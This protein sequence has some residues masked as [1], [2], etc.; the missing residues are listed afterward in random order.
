M[1]GLAI[2]L[3]VFLWLLTFPT[4]SD[5]GWLN[6]LIGSIAIGIG[7]FI[8]KTVARY[9]KLHDLKTSI[10]KTKTIDD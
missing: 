1:C 5:G 7:F 9:A 8:I 4:L 6:A 2:G 10:P 3:G